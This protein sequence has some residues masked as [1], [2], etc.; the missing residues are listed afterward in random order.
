MTRKL[1]ACGERKFS[2]E[3]RMKKVHV[4]AS[5]VLE[6]DEGRAPRRADV[7]VCG[8][9]R[10]AAA[11]FLPLCPY[12]VRTLPAALALARRVVTCR[13]CRARLEDTFFS[14]RTRVAAP[15]GPLVRR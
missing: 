10:Y 8:E 7:A 2:P 12:R 6:G 9:W 15:A 5:A 3:A 1:G 11:V 4:T 14:T 13:K